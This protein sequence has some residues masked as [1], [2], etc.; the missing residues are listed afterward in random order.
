MYKL[1]SVFITILFFAYLVSAQTEPKATPTPAK[2]DDTDVVRISTNLVQVDAIVVDKDGNQ[3][4]GLTADDFQLFQDDK[5]QQITS[6]SYVGSAPDASVNKQN[7]GNKNNK[8]AIPP[9]VVRVRPENAGRILTFIV[10]DGNCGASQI[11]MI[12]A[13]EAIQKFVR[14]QMQPNDLV[15][16]YQTRSGSSVLQ[17][18]TSDKAQLLRV[19][20]KIRW[21][22]PTGSCSS[23]NGSFFAAAER[24]TIDAMTINGTKTLQI[25]SPEEKK[26]REGREDFSRNNQVV[27][28]IGVVRYVVKGLEKVGGRKVVFFMSDGLPLMS[29]DKKNLSAMD[30][31]RDLTDLANRSAVV[32]NTID[33][34]GVYNSSMIEAR[35][36]VATRDDA[37]ASEKV[38]AERV[39]EDSI[40]Q[41]GLF[42]LANETGGKFY[43]GSNNLDTHVNKA[44]SLEKGYYLLA[45][46][47]DEETFK[48][49]KY[50]KIEIKVS[51]PEL[52]VVSRA[53]FIG[54]PD[55]E[56]KSKSRTG[57]SELYDAIIAPLPRPGL[58]LELTAFFANTPAQGNFV[59]SMTHLDGEDITVVNEPDGKIKMVFDVV[60]VTLNE[61]NEVVDEF[62][63][64]HTIH[65]EAAALPYIKQNGLIYQTDV[66]IKKAGTYNFRVA[67]RDASSKSIGSAGQVIQI[68]D[69]KKND[70]YLSG[71]SLSAVD[72]NGKFKTP[73]AV[74]PEA[75]FT[76]I[77]SMAIPAVRQFKNNSIVAYSYTV[78]NA[79]L[80]KATNQPKLSVQVKLF[81]DGKIIQEGNPAPAELEKQTDLSRINDYSYIR[82]TLP[83]GDYTL[84]IIVKD[85]ITNQTTTQSIDFE[86]VQ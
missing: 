85:L 16:I 2:G 4:K 78:Y 83:N 64:T 66:P 8:N 18:Y 48:G 53:G 71:L 56:T 59:R 77:A 11:G 72:E 15:A 45:Y 40:R 63:H 54:K 21:Y 46:Q 49:K 36:D 27:G 1:T 3:V 31:L 39:N 30:V 68:P 69:L 61:K 80:D 28:S 19:A 47:P 38:V 6:I 74:K 33:V 23:N 13:K 24:N 37:I 14:E 29:R 22:P 57:D 70:L 51:R 32:F 10:D 84:Q 65:I 17:Q 75:A 25:E 79:Q 62:N 60:A 81:R 82:L 7:A 20:N 76:P 58:N 26:A 55:E 5:P 43:K 34:R 44:L 73:A 9:P 67:M 86:I 50:H 12:A 52:R 35:D 42:F 41:D